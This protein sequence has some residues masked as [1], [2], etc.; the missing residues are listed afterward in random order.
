[1]P[2]L[3]NQ[4]SISIFLPALAGGGAER[5]MLHLAQGLA[6]RGLKTDLVLAK[7]EGDYLASVPSSIRVVDLQARFPVLI[8]KTIALRHYL[9][10]EQPTV[11]F[12][13]LDIL[14]SAIWAQ[15]LAGVSTKTI[16]CVQTHLSRQFRNHQ[17]HT[18]GRIRPLLVRWFYPWADTIVAASHGVAAD[19]ASITGLSVDQIPVIHNPVVTPE[20]LQKMQAPVDHPWFAAGEPPVILGVGR[21]VSQKDF[22]TLLNAFA[23]VRQQCS[24]RLMILGEGEDRSQLEAQTQQLGLAADVALPGFVDNPYAYMAKAQV[25]A[26]SSIFEGFGN[27]VAEAMAAGTPIVSTDCESGPAEILANGEYGKLVPVGDAEALAE[28]IVSTIQQPLPAEVLRQ[29][30]KA[31]SVEEV[32]EQYI[33]VLQQVIH[34]NSLQTS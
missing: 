3:L 1:M 8:S 10:Q 33:D 6:E 11:L 22:P 24:A 32:T 25:F 34:Q 20:V 16:M 13:A 18:M 4:P 31:F 14:S 12:S 26:L 17:P 15:R 27:V 28:A 9:Q 19:V 21:L 30:A 23:R 2:Q 7:A 5:A 29:R